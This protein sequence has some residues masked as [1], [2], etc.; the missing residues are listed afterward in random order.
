[1]SSENYKLYKKHQAEIF[2]M[3]YDIFERAP[4]PNIFGF[5]TKEEKEEYDKKM[6]EF[7]KLEE[8]KIKEQFKELG[9]EIK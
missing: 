2:N 4:I 7:L 9:F 5:E 8:P 1:M 6:E 3:I